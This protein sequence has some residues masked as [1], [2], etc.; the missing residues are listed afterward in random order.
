MIPK[1]LAEQITGEIYTWGIRK[2]G[3]SLSM[4][5]VR[6]LGVMTVKQILKA[7][8]ESYNSTDYVHFNESWEFEFYNKTIEEIEKI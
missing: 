7:V 1:D 8:S 2:E 4:F 5:E 3:Q 6:Q